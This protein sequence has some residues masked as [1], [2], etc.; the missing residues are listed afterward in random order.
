MNEDDLFDLSSGGGPDI[1][2]GGVFP[3][4]PGLTGP[5]APA[6]LS[7]PIDPATLAGMTGQT[8][9]TP[10]DAPGV[11]AAP[12]QGPPLDP[13]TEFL[14]NGEPL[15]Q[16][17]NLGQALLRAGI[18][19]LAANGAGVNTSGTVAAGLAGFAD[20]LQEQRKA[21]NDQRRQALTDYALL[22]Q[23][24]QRQMAEQAAT[25]KVAALQRLKQLN[26]QMADMIDVDPEG[27]AAAMTASITPKVEKLGMGES[28]V[29]VKNG[30]AIP[31]T[32]PAGLT[33][34]APQGAAATPG[35]L[36]NAPDP[37]DPNGVLAGVA[38][39]VAAQV[40]ALVAGRMPMS[41]NMY[42]SPVGQFLLQKASE[43]DP[44]FDAVNYNS[45]NAV[46]KDFTSGKAA[47]TI[48]ALNTAIGHL[49]VLQEKGDALDKNLD[50]GGQ[51]P[52][53]NWA[54][55]K[56]NTAKGGGDVTSYNAAKNSVAGELVNAY[57]AGG[58]SEADIQERLKDLSENQSPEQRQKTLSTIGDLLG[59]KLDA[60]N[61]QYRRSMGT[62]AED[63]HF[64]TPD[65]ISTLKK[66]GATKV[67]DLTKSVFSPRGASIADPLAP[68]SAMEHAPG[69]ALD[70]LATP[71]H[72]GSALPFVDPLAPVAAGPVIYDAATYNPTRK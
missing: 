43:L 10:A 19:V 30:Q 32:N 28:L 11:A 44:N 20:N 21:Q 27:V 67:P 54:E 8:G 31:L 34:D 63:T 9:P 12:P 18:N 4:F 33:M 71:A 66:L 52:I 7:Q 14:Q 29:Q 37:Q 6:D 41:P 23:I 57:R 61:D 68:R 62:A 50:A 49:G 69:M 53:L 26:P 17:P 25:Q 22:G 5:M 59:S 42:R 16:G 39:G 47:T 2:T 55:N 13:T 48:N 15:V 58:G 72:P 40:K 64:Y 65:A 45:R 35:S 3:Q 51:Y 46:R 38:P 1:M 36:P 70:P 24:K 60:M 56:I